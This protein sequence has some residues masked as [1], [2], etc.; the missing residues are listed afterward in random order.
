MTIKWRLTRRSFLLRTAAAGAAVSLPA[1]T[2]SPARASSS[3]TAAVRLAAKIRRLRKPDSRVLTGE[4]SLNGWE[5][6]KV[7]D[8]RGSV[9]TRPIVGTPLAGVQ[10][11]MGDVETIL[12]H[13]VRRFHYEVE[14]LHAGDVTG[15]R[16]PTG[17]RKP[18]AESNLASGTAVLIRP[19]HYPV[20]VRGNFFALQQIVIRDILAELDGVVRWGGD[21]RRPNEALFSID[22]PP[23]DSHLALIASRLR[24]WRDMAGRGAG[25]HVDVMAHGRR[26]AAKIVEKRQRSA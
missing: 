21:D 17:E 16:A 22:V 5:M 10:M 18:T 6:E 4:R 24:G 26:S 14:E 19:G 9:Y 7:A 25:G 8:D 1:L 15:W 12:V 20:G 3:D 13:L 2:A 11:R 23:D